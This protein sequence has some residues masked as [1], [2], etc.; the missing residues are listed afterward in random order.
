M[1]NGSAE[2]GPRALQMLRDAAERGEPF[3]VAILDMQMPEIDGLELA[4]RI[5]K[6]PSISSTK[7]IM[8][9]SVGK[10]IEAEEAYQ[11]SI[12]AYLSKPI[13]QSR[14][15]DVIAT[16]MSV[17]EEEDSAPPSTD[18][19]T[20]SPTDAPFVATNTLREPKERPHAPI[21]V[22]EDNAVNQKV[23]VRMLEKLGYRVDVVANGLEAL[24]ALSR[25][26]YAAILMDVQ[27][28]EMDGY[29]TTKEIRRREEDAEGR[30]TPIVA[31]TA[32][33]MQG[34]REKALEAGMDDYVSKPVSSEKLEAVLERWMPKDHVMMAAP[35]AAPSDSKEPA[36]LE[37]TGPSLD[38]GVVESLR[39]LGGDEMLSEL[40][41]LFLNDTSSNLA[42]LKDAIDKHDANFV[43]RVAHT[44][45]GS[46]DNMGAL[47]MAAICGELE[48]AGVSEDLATAPALIE[49]LEAEFEHARCALEAEIAR[50]Q[51]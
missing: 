12:D 32:N 2:D 16:V 50:S 43:K 17:R 31:M 33:A 24:E 37:G 28:P 13:K 27:M 48:D 51:G 26:P 29:E 49:R 3:N 7:L 19:P 39:E 18:V 40:A 10:R 42:A 38:A 35:D 5:K 14:L 45:K 34:D 30:R 22:A 9:S 4:Q 41:P 11:A 20:L 36:V 23:A 46:S 21:L 44:L 1:K 8:M 47:R 25:I 15:H 6:D